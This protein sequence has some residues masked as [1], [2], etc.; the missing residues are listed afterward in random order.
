MRTD[1]R[2]MKPL[3]WTLLAVLSTLWGG[4]FFFVGVAVRS[5][6]PFTIVA[7]RLGL[8]AVA[9]NV[10]VPAVG[11][12]MPG[13][14]RQWLA[15]LGMGVLNNAIPFSL[16]VWGQ[17]HIAGG[18][19]SILNAATPFFTI[20]AAHFLTDDEKLDGGRALGIF[21]G[22]SGVVFVV[23]PQVLKGVGANGLAQ[24]AVL[25]AASSYAFAAVYGRRF[26]RAGLA[27]IVTAAG[28]VTAS[29][30]VLI[31]LAL[32]VDRPWRLPPPSWETWGAV[33]G[34]A[35]FSTAL[36]Y[37]LY[38]RILATAGATNLLLVTFLIPVSAILLSTTILGE[39]LGLRHLIGM[40]ILGLGLAVIDGRL[41]RIIRRKSA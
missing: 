27:P 5:L 6:P 38:F 9:L 12:R 10:I 23:G 20:V 28:Q 25:G 8:A 40:G 26:R 21:I 37:I 35:L 11:L 32:F 1:N 24:L 33:V 18:L 31:P 36:A 41:I 2:A 7:L 4:S 17:T 39:R 30:V 19:A 22:F 15:F 3:E 29:T 34:L 13:D 16:I 14:W